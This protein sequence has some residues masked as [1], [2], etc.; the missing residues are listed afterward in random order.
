MLRHHAF[1]AR[2]NAH[3]NGSNLELL[4]L[5]LSHRQAQDSRAGL[6]TRRR[7]RGVCAEFGRSHAWAENKYRPTADRFFD[8]FGTPRLIEATQAPLSRAECK[9]LANARGASGA[10]CR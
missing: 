10:R 4:A 2:G 1:D 6:R 9:L 5:G 7:Y 3:M 8:P